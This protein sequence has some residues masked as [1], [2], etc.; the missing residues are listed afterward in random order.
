MKREIEGYSNLE[1]P[2]RSTSPRD[3]LPSFEAPLSTDARADR[4]LVR[5]RRLASSLGI[6]ELG[7]AAVT[8]PIWADVSSGYIGRDSDCRG[9]RSACGNVPAPSPRSRYASCR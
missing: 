6:E 8:V 5:R 9:E 7:I 2:M 3:A 1:S 4:R